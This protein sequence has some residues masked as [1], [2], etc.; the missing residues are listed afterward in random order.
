MIKNQIEK[1]YAEIKENITKDGMK[2][3]N[4]LESLKLS[5]EEYKEKNVKPLAIKRLQGELI[6][7]KLMD[8]EPVE[9]TDAELKKEIEGILKKFESADVLKRLKELYIPGTKYYEELRQ[10]TAYRKLIDSFF[11]TKAK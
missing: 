2:V 8:I 9:V 10:R 11:E 1:V 4:Y 6:L 3:T 7:H 5:E